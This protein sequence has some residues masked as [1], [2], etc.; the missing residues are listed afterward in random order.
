MSLTEKY[1]SILI[2]SFVAPH[3]ANEP[4]YQAIIALLWH[5]QMDNKQDG[6]SVH[7]HLMFM[8][9]MSLWC[10]ERNFIISYYFSFLK[11]CRVC[12]YSWSYLFMYGMNVICIQYVVLISTGE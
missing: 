8:E 4:L 12:A 6:N 1:Q 9:I 7:I 11:F 3:P 5:W 2:H 10:K